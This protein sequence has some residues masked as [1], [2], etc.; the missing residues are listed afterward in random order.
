MP[1][2]YVLNTRTGKKERISRI[3]QMHANKQNPIDLSKRVISEPVLVLKDIK[4]GDTL[5]NE[6]NPIVLEAMT[7]PEPVISSRLNQNT[8]R[9]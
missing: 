4:T 6:D 3:M 5:C 8:G 2:P 7:F 9:R 1:V